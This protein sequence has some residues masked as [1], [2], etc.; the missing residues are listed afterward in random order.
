MTQRRKKVGE[1]R[2]RGFKRQI[3]RISSV[4]YAVVSGIF[5]CYDKFVPEMKKCLKNDSF[6]YPAGT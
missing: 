5:V 2:Q 6:P 1:P 3:A 4:T